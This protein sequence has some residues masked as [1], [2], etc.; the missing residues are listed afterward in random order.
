MYTTIALELAKR[1]IKKEAFDVVTAG[2]LRDVV[3]LLTS[4]NPADTL[5]QSILSYTGIDSIGGLTEENITE[6]GKKIAR[7][8]YSSMSDIMNRG[9]EIIIKAFERNVIDSY[10]EWV[11]QKNPEY[12]ERMDILNRIKVYLTKFRGKNQQRY[13]KAILMWQNSPNYKKFSYLD[14]YYLSREYTPITSSMHSIDGLKKL[15]D[16]DML[17][18]TVR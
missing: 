17:M 1:V 7:E 9:S 15:H 10:E 4:D 11:L 2:R 5:K 16:V 13:A 8:G 6:I 3:R 18:K 14:W 12:D